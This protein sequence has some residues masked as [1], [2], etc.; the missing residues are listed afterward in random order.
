[1]PAHLIVT[2][3]KLGTV[4]RVAAAPA[5]NRLRPQVALARSN[6]AH[7]IPDSEA[8]RMDGPLEV[9]G[10]DAP[11]DSFGST[12]RLPDV[13]DDAG[14]VCRRFVDFVLPVH[15]SLVYGAE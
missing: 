11:Y 4:T 9:L 10:R 13:I 2:G 14:G 3:G 1:V 6:M 8:A 5:L 15:F 12:V 7:K